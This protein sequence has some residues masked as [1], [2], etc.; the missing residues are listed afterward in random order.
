MA[1][2][3][4]PETAT[5]R[6]RGRR[7]GS[8]DTRAAVLGAARVAFAEHGYK[9]ATIRGIARR[10]GVDPAL[11]IQYFTNKEELFRASLELVL[12]P[13]EE[14][15]KAFRDTEGTPGFRLASFYFGMWETPGVRESLTAM[16]LS[17][18]SEPEARRAVK[19][20]MSGRFIGPIGA[21]IGAEKA[22]ERVPL[23]ATQMLGMAFLRYVIP[24]D[25]M[26]SMPVQDV[27]RLVAPV[28]DRYLT[29]DLDDCLTV[30]LTPLT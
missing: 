1:D 19:A 4:D 15:E 8:P 14:L 30:P 9:K 6:P 21:V 17:A 25:P 12:G 2:V 24:T 23:C 26:R 20:L 3:V 10:A 18:A 5:P 27:I 7:P 29:E 13:S 22:A 16:A 11:V 28:L